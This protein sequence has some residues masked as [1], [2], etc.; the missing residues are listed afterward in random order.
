M[1]NVLTGG[2]INSTTD[3]DFV[4]IINPDSGP[5][6]KDFSPPVD[7]V[8]QIQKLNSLPNVQTVG[9]VRVFMPSRSIS[10]VR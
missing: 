8:P 1:N 9:Y 5:G 2:R 7:F 4:V 6:S 3:L 10:S